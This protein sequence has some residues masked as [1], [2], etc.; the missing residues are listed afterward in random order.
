M[1]TLVLSRLK[2][3]RSAVVALALVFA[4]CTC[5]GENTRAVCPPCD[6][7]QICGEETDY[8]CVDL[9]RECAVD[10]ECCPGQICNTL[11]PRC[12]DKFEQCDPNSEEPTC[13]VE[14]QVCKQMG[15]APKG[16]G[17]TFE[18]C[19][20]NGACGDG[21]DC[22]NGYCVGEAPCNG[23]CGPGEVCTPVNNRCFSTAGITDEA[24]KLPSSCEMSCEPGTILVFKDGYNVFN[25]CSIQKRDCECLPL[26]PVKAHDNVRHSDAV[27]TP[28][29]ILVSAYSA[30]HGDLVLHT[31]SKEDLRREKTEWI[32]GLPK[33]GAI[34][35]DPNGPRGG[36]IAPGPDVGTYTS[37]AYNEGLTL[38]AYYAIKD[39]ADTLGDLRF[40]SR[41]GESGGFQIH[42]VDE[43]G[44]VGLYTSMTLSPDKAP[45]VAY[46]QRGGT[47]NEASATKVKVARA[48]VKNPTKADDW[49]I[50]TIDT[51]ARTP[52]PCAWPTCSD[53]EA[54]VATGQIPDL[55]VCV[56]K[57]P[58]ASSCRPSESDPTARRCTGEE[59]CGLD[60]QNAPACF[61]SLRARTL[62][63]M[64]EGNGLQPSIAYMD[65]RLVVVWY[66]RANGQLKG[67]ISTSDSASAGAT[68]SA[69]VVLDDGGMFG[70][71]V[72]QF[73]SVAIGPSS[74]G[75]RIAVAYFDSTER[76]LK[77]LRAGADFAQPEITV[78]D[79]GAGSQE[80]DPV[81]FVGA[82]TSIGF[83][84]S[85]RLLIAYQNSTGGDLRL[86]REGDNGQFQ[87]STLAQEGA[88]GF[89]VNLL[90]DAR[91]ATH[92]V[93]KAASATRSANRLELV[94][95]P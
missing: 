67:A 46:F 29:K 4:A 10:G 54:C 76:Q 31:Y 2:F 42:T 50:T 91:I 26:P 39:G 56:K 27:A 15:I 52:P 90:P 36:R 65:N 11:I 41:A 95:L 86:A 93:I 13:L 17:C 60:N 14:G 69:P 82:D 8:V 12:V 92:A 34:V 40:A 61:P 51:G 74:A 35:A 32:D 63:G 19:D 38:I 43:L 81:L 78:V 48:K 59:V 55:G 7:N 73:P 57:A 64:P 3:L 89:Y 37:I 24:L 30:D 75:K 94:R 70:N 20:A 79:R 6:E 49:N 62:V 28:S 9:N 58:T 84:E 1:V 53:N 18:R 45:V 16:P 68:F 25:T 71:D 47:G 83:G 44:D 5:T 87:L 88:G 66:D 22:F 77:L 23:A 80:A 72:G 85:G 21:L 33:S